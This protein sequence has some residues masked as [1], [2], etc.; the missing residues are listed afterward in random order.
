MA[1]ITLEYNPR[2]KG[3]VDLLSRIKESGFFTIKTKSSS[4]PRAGYGN[5]LISL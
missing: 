1:T 2:V 5:T 4:H 3:A